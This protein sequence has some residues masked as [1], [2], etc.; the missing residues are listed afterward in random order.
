MHQHA[1]T[2]YTVYIFKFF[3]FEETPFRSNLVIVLAEEW[4]DGRTNEGD[5]EENNTHP[6]SA[7]SEKLLNVRS[8]FVFFLFF[9]FFCLLVFSTPHV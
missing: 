2:T 5:I 8:I 6:P 4:I 7:E 9:S 3:R 1:F